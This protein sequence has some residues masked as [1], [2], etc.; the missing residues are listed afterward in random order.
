MAYFLNDNTVSGEGR[1]EL[2][3]PRRALDIDGTP[4]TSGGLVHCTHCQAALLSDARECPHCGRWICS[5]CDPDNLAAY[6]QFRRCAPED[7]EVQPARVGADYEP[8][9]D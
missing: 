6:A 7:P 1:V 4:L 5:V 3:F 2:G 9:H 8:A